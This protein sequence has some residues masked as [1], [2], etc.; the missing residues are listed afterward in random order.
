MECLRVCLCG[1]CGPRRPPVRS[2][3]SGHPHGWSPEHVLGQVRIVD[4]S[5]P[6]KMVF[7]LCGIKPLFVMKDK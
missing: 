5:Y 2:S 4:G 3:H 6:N 7:L 1:I